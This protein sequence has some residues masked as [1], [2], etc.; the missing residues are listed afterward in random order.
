MSG[1]RESSEDLLAEFA[2]AHWLMREAWLGSVNW[3]IGEPE[4]LAA[5]RAETSCTW[6]P[7]RTPIERMVDDATGRGRDFIRQFMTWHNRAVW[8]EANGRVCDVGNLTEAE[9]S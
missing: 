2:P 3:A 5:F 8:G 4:I 6:E 7:G 1:R 9:A